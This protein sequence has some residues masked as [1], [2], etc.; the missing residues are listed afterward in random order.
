MEMKL[1]TAAMKL[2]A[3]IM[4]Q[5]QR[6]LIL[7]SA[8]SPKSK[9]GVAT[10]RSTFNTKDIVSQ[11]GGILSGPLNSLRTEAGLESQETVLLHDYYL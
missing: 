3:C 7:K 1:A 8:N 6:S 5:M 4:Y 10:V 2:L 9:T 11:N